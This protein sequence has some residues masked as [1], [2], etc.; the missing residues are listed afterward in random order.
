[1]LEPDVAIA[2]ARATAHH[3]DAYWRFL[4]NTVGQP[5]DPTVEPAPPQFEEIFGEVLVDRSGAAELDLAGMA[6]RAIAMGPWAEDQLHPAALGPRQANV[7]LHRCS[8]VGVVPA[9]QMDDRY[10][11]I[12]VVEALRIDPRPLPVIVKDTV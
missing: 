4:I 2:P 12:A 6:H 8:G 10:I 3:K 7:V 1:M 5:L 11:G 9:R